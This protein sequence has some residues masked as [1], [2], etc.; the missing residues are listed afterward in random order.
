MLYLNICLMVI[1]ERRNLQIGDFILFY[2]FIEGVVVLE[3][4]YARACREDCRCPRKSVIPCLVILIQ[5]REVRRRTVRRTISYHYYHSLGTSLY[6]RGRR[7]W[8]PR[9]RANCSLISRGTSN[10]GF[11]VSVRARSCN[12]FR[13][14]WGWREN[15]RRSFSSRDMLKNRKELN[16]RL[17]IRMCRTERSR[18]EIRS[19]ETCRIEM[20]GAEMYRSDMCGSEACRTEI[21]R[22]KICRTVRCRIE[23]CRTEVCRTKIR[24]TDLCRIEM[25]R[26]VICRTKIHRTDLCRIEMCRTEICRAEMWRTL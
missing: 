21:Y 26:T 15:A 1:F 12:L 22:T 13:W 23:M 11:L 4:C 8:A 5:L 16:G 3:E 6:V 7:N 24:R 2:F 14:R 19:V 18:T 9:G 17:Q 25:C 20:C 10:P